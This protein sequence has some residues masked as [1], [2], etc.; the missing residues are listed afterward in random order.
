MDEF[1]DRWS[2][3]HAYVFESCC[4]ALATLLTIDVFPNPARPVRRRDDTSH[5]SVAGMIEMV[6]KHTSPYR[7]FDAVNGY[8][9][10]T[11]IDTTL[12]NI[13]HSRKEFSRSKICD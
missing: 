5:R 12:E 8:F 11:E 4:R 2:N 3:V 7:Y 6:N 1:F 9:S 10:D 13:A